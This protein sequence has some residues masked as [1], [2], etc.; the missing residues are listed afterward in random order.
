MAW[1]REWPLFR[2]LMF[3][4]VVTQNHLSG[5]VK[6]VTYGCRKK[7][8][9]QI[10]IVSCLDHK[11]FSSLSNLIPKGHTSVFLSKLIS[12]FFFFF[13]AYTG[14]TFPSHSKQGT[15]VFPKEKDRE[16]AKCPAN[17]YFL[18]LRYLIIRHITLCYCLVYHVAIWEAGFYSSRAQGY[19]YVQSLC[20]A[21]RVGTASELISV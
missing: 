5:C 11:T 14:V 19:C 4:Y 1:L 20:F 2:F 8:V 15:Q 6:W 16:P 10:V 9:G 7:Y 18:G 13:D 21:M 17:L 12:W 3:A